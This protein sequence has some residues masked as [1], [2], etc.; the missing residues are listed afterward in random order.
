MKVVLD[1]VRNH[2]GQLFFYD[3]N[4]NGKPDEYIGGHGLDVAGRRAAASTIRTGIRAACRRSR[5]RG[6]AGR[7]PII[8]LNMPEINR[9]CR[10]RGGCSA[11]PAR[12][13]ASGAS[14]I[15]TTRRSAR[16]AISPAG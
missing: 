14:S 4:L 12:T 15:T 10:R 6:N 11:R 5:P 3:M 13:T 16:S 7:A 1:I 8:F 2:M 9:T